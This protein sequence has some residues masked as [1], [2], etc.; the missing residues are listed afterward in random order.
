MAAEE[1]KGRFVKGRYVVDE[2]DEPKAE[3][4][5]KEDEQPTIEHLIKK[6]SENVDMTIESVVILGKK[7]FMSEEGRNHIEAKTREIGS[8]LQKAVGE[9]AEA[10]QRF[11]QKK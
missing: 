7:L 8:E 10:A 2:E 3:T 4:S 5:A 11:I 9:I 1:M 6:T